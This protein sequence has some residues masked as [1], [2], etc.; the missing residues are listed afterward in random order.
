MDEMVEYQRLKGG[1]PVGAS[2]LCQLDRIV[3]ALLVIMGTVF[4]RD[5]VG[6]I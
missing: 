3:I 6:R 1:P 5:P 2:C 4:E